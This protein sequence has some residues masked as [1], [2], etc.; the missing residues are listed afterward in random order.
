MTNLLNTSNYFWNKMCPDNIAVPFLTLDLQYWKTTL[1][2]V[3]NLYLTCLS[4]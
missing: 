2:S 4:L 3:I 1:H